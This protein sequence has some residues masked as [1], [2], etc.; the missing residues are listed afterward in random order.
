[1]AAGP[2]TIARDLA[3][4]PVISVAPTTPLAVAGELMVHHRVS[5][6][7]VIDEDRLVPIGIVSTLDLA[8]VLAW[9]EA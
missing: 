3:Q 5:H 4:Q 9:G 2:E 6:L 8:G 1:V 7:V